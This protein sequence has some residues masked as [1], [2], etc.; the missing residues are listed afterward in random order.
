ME[1]VSVQNILLLI[2]LLFIYL[3]ICLVRIKSQHPSAWNLSQV[4]ITLR[5]ESLATWLPDVSY[6]TGVKCLQKSN[7]NI[8]SFFPRLHRAE[9]ALS[10]LN[11]NMSVALWSFI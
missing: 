7:K 3:F 4:S 8:F 6:K 9:A 10:L 1:N 2:S 5:V 11:P